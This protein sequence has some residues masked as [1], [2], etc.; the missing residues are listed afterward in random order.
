MLDV[1]LKTVS[2]AKISNNYAKY[3]F[4][5][6][7]FAGVLFGTFCMNVFCGYFYDRLG[8]YSS[9]FIET[10][11]NINVD[12][13]NLFLYAFKDILL[14]MLMVIA[15]SF[16][17]AGG[18]FLNLYCAYKGFTIALLVAS[19]V[20]KYGIGG[21]LIYVISIFPHYITY[22]ILVLII[23]YTGFYLWE[24]MKHFRK[25][26]CMGESI[27]GSVRM[28]LGEV[29]EQKKVLLVM[30]VIAM[31]ILITAFLEVYVNS[32]MIRKML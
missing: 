16:T 20:L 17:S 29:F 4:L 6:W 26:R 19:S 14:E 11:K 30:A 15:V 8:I 32:V 23:V 13:K 7:F 1:R 27:A 10:Y 28:F 12:Y 22:G 2:V 3:R 9:Y 24:K 21:V 25:N 18:I 5:I 31:L